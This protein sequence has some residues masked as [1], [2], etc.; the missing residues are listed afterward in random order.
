MQTGP[1]ALTLP[2]R[3]IVDKAIGRHDHRLMN[4]M[5][6]IFVIAYIRSVKTGI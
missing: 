3:L 4:G 5:E 1:R 6:T 2:N